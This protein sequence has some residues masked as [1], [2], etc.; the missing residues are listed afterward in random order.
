M[1]PFEEE[2]KTEMEGSFVIQGKG[3]VVQ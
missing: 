1:Q 3:R 2:E